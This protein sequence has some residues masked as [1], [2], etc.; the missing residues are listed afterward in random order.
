MPSLSFDRHCAEIVTQTDL[1]RS[2]LKGADLSAP[3]PTCPGWN[4]GQL[5]RHVGGAHRWVETIVRTRATEEVS[6]EQVNNVFGYRDEDPAVLDAW[7]AE[8]AQQLADALRA[9]GPDAPVWT[10]APG[11]TPVFWARRMVHE[12]VVHRADVSFVAPATAP[13]TAPAS[14]H[15]DAAAPLGW[16]SPATGPVFSVD[17]DV[18]IDALD[19]WM[20]FGPL[21]PVFEA[22]PELR[23]LMSD[24]RTLHFHATD[25]APEAAA[26][27]L[28]SLDGNALAW[29]RAHAEATVTVRGPVAE[30]VLLVYGR[31]S[32]QGGPDAAGGIEIVGDTPLLDAW[33]DG[34]SFWLKE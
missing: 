21:P 12:T 13:A 11:G 10:V 27:W 30:L 14:G 15:T 25:T 26:E 7:L 32:T 5:L 31:R 2:H 24:G 19:E 1:L 33:L 22:E 17:E 23:K 28:V 20:S 29:R 16:P 9:A 6:D 4:L 8:G 18:A 34:T 3:V